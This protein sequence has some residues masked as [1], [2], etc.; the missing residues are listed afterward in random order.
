MWWLN[1]SRLQCPGY[2]FLVSK[3][4]MYFSL[5]INEVRVGLIYHQWCNLWLVLG[6]LLHAI[7]DKWLNTCHRAHHLG[8]LKTF[9]VILMTTSPFYP[10]ALWAGG[11]LSSQSGRAGGQAGGQAIVRVAARLAEPITARWIF[12][13]RIQRI[14]YCH[15]LH[16]RSW[17]TG[18]LFSL[19]LCSLWWMQ[20]FG[21]VWL[22]D[23]TRLF[24]QYTISL[25]SLCKFIWRHW[26]Y[27][28]LSDI[29]CRVCE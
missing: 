6:H 8:A 21:Y 17:K 28:H 5:Y 3:A 9:S 19:L 29:F 20:I 26:T 25:S 27:K 2:L 10:S 11:V 18:N 24:L 22:A 7:W 23:R 13:I 16:I 12:S 15:L 14:I 1:L 4:S